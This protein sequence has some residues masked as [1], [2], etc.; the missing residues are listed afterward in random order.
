MD[1]GWEAEKRF[2]RKG[3]YAC[4]WLIHADVWKKPTPHYCIQY[5][6]DTT[7]NYH[8]PININELKEKVDVVLSQEMCNKPS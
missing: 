1:F 4:L 5:K 8:S 7:Q 2:K 6:C 3:T